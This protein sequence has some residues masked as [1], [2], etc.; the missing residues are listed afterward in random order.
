MIISP[1][2]IN[3]ILEPLK[4]RGGKIVLTG[5]CFD[6]IHS[7]HIEFLQKAKRSGD[8]LIVLIESDKNIRRM[9]GKNRPVNT[10]K[11]RTQALEALGFIDF[12]V[13]LPDIISDDYYYNLTKLIQ[14]DIIAITKNDPL[15]QKKKEQAESVG[16][17]V[18]EIM[19]RDE[20]FSSTKIIEDL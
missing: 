8:I 6:V 11:K 2:I 15:L 20:K 5:G 13:I 3:S 1:D 4:T 12:I 16:G 19:D 14:P 9:K 18:Q 17:R 7:A 10:I